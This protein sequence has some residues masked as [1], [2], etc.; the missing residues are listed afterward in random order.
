MA[1]MKHNAHFLL[2][3]LNGLARIANA[4][5]VSSTK[6]DVTFFSDDRKRSCMDSLARSSEEYSRLFRSVPTSLTAAVL[7]P[8]CFNQRGEPAVLLTLRSQ[9]LARHAG[10]ISFP[11]GIADKSDMSATETALRETEE[12]LGIPPANV[13]VWGPIHPIPALGSEISVTPVVAF[14]KSSSPE[15]LMEELVVNKN[16]VEKVIMPSLASL[17]DPR[18][19]E[20]TNW[21][22]PGVPRHLAPV[23]VL[24]GDERIWGLTAK[25]L[26]LCMAS[27]LPELYSRKCLVQLAGADNGGKL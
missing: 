21:T 23:F 26:D 7:V 27:V 6:F 9:N 24:D 10:L 11:G 8:F 2:W 4:R 12:E 3:S 19:W 18:G 15:T 17:C 20:Y 5:R 22:Y 13:D 25:I 14:V 1:F 16:E